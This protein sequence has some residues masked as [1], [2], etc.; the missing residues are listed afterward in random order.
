MS[1]PT[2]EERVAILEAQ[3]A[4]LLANTPIATPIKD[5]REVLSYAPP[6]EER[7]RRIDAA[8]QAIREKERQQARRRKSPRV[9]R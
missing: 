1:S 2:I 3:V 5:W 9:R 8:G 6:D 4:R 7:M